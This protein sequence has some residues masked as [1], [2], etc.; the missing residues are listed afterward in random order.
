MEYY[1]E[2]LRKKDI[3]LKIKEDSNINPKD[4]ESTKN[5]SFGIAFEEGN[6]SLEVDSFI[7]SEL[8]QKRNER[9]AEESAKI[10]QMME[11]LN[12]S[13][14][15]AIQML[16]QAEENT[17]KQRLLR[18]DLFVDRSRKRIDRKIKFEIVPDLL[19]EYNLDMN[20]RS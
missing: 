5:K 15:K 20:G 8:I 18:P 16:R 2:E 1:K 9:L 11:L 4:S 12:I 14:D 13:K 19:D 17:D 3:I 7:E 10:T 6:A